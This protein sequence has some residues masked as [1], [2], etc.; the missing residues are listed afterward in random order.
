MNIKTTH[1]ILQPHRCGFLLKY[2]KY[3]KS[4][5]C[6]MSW[7]NK[8]DTTESIKYTS[9][10][11]TVKPLWRD[12]GL[13]YQVWWRHWWHSRSS[14]VSC[15]SDLEDVQQ[16]RGFHN[17]FNQCDL[18][19]NATHPM[20]KRHRRGHLQGSQVFITSSPH[21]LPCV[22]ARVF[23][24]HPQVLLSY[25]WEQVMNPEGP[26]V[27]V[28]LAYYIFRWDDSY[29]RTFPPNFLHMTFSSLSS[30]NLSNFQ[31]QKIWAVVLRKILQKKE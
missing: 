23:D 12:C 10:A 22:H 26:S 14:A 6:R 8:T 18:L 2:W 24:R 1:G 5:N 19:K 29:L 11:G 15:G 16:K 25:S 13:G 20:N 4:F 31:K 30:T 28:I 7:L 21:P 3:Y 27:F 9:Y 17:V